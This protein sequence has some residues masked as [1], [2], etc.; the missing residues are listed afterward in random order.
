MGS[1]KLCFV[2]SP[3]GEHG[4]E[5]R[6]RADQVLKHIIAPAVAECGYDAF[7][8]DQ[9]SEPG[10]IT[11]QVIQHI[12]EAPLVIADL[13]G[14]NPNVFYELAIRH[15]IRKPLVQV[16]QKG[17][18]IPFDVAGMRT[19]PVDHRDLD[20]VE[21]TKEEILKQIRSVEGKQADQIESPVSVSVDLQSLRHSQSPSDRFQATIL[22]AI[23]QLRTEVA[24]LSH[25]MAKQ[26]FEESIAS[27]PD[28]L[29]AS[30]GLT[31]SSRRGV[32]LGELRELLRRAQAMGTSEVEVQSKQGAIER[33]S[34]S[35]QR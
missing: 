17:E 12:V 13:T 25:S 18:K 20:S 7:R 23:E 34:S 35:P 14:M 15:A 27:L 8:A 30:M 5:I 28:D 19:I 31:T 16:I 3:I 21:E 26:Q 6:K 2:I 22:S 10:M 4:S 29:K 9:I 1:K 33:P 24:S 32:T 11:S